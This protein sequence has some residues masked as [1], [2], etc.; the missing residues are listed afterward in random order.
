MLFLYSSKMVGG[1]PSFSDRI[2]CVILVGLLLLKVVLAHSFDALSDDVVLNT[3]RRLL[4]CAEDG[5]CIR[6]SALECQHDHP[7]NSRLCVWIRDAKFFLPMAKV[8]FHRCGLKLKSS[9]V[10]WV[11][12]MELEWVDAHDRRVV[13]VPFF[14]LLPKLAV[15]AVYENLYSMLHSILS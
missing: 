12:H 13:L 11:V 6:L 5:V 14:D 10:V 8:R 1:P 3:C 9:S 4:C 2:W 7:T 15:R